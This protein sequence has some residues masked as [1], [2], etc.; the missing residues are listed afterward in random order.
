MARRGEGNGGLIGGRVSEL[1]V[2]E[3]SGMADPPHAARWCLHPFISPT[4]FIF[5]VAI[6]GFSPGRQSSAECERSSRLH[7][8]IGLNI[9]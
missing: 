3:R 2:R 5:G 4:G 9:L 1:C 6:A 7:V 8:I